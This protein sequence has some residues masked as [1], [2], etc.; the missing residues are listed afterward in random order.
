MLRSLSLHG[1][2]P[3]RGLSAAFGERLN[4]ITGDNGLGKS[5]LLDVC[6]WALTGTWP[7]GRTALPSSRGKTSRAE[8]TFELLGRSSAR[9]GPRTVGF[10]YHT[11]TWPRPSPRP[12]SAGLVIYAA[13]DGG[14]AVWDPA[15]NYWRDPASGL[16]TGEEQPRA[17]QFT[18]D[19]LADGLKDGERVLCNGLI[20]DWVNWY[21]ES[22]S[23]NGQS[24]SDHGPAS[25]FASL[26]E[27][28]AALAHPS[29]RMACA[30]PRR[31]YID[32]PRKYPVLALPYGDVPYPQWSAGMRR[33]VGLAYLLV[34]AWTE[35]AQAARLR[36]EEPLRRLTLIVDEVEAHL[37]P[38]WM[39]AILPALLR[40]E[41]RLRAEIDVQVL[42]A[43]HSP[44]I[45]AS[46]E[47]YFQAGRDKLFWFD[48]QRDTVRF[49]E[50]PWVIRGDVV[51]WLTSDIFGLRQ[52][53]SREAEAAIE[54]AEALMRGDV[55]ELPEGLKTREA[56]DGALRRL[57]SDLDPFW[58]RWYVETHGTHA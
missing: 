50:Y 47:P 24:A 55:E 27:V 20:Q 19:T 48:L 4:V 35:H 53:R 11:Q 45:L 23:G 57:L 22:R 25:P 21:Y 8:I 15:R 49:R 40:V 2:G 29:E 42:T 41:T 46:L 36:R 10:D 54:A 56:I 34:W 44:L 6:F 43:T 13:V 39:R 51:G 37:H 18:P 26:E 30:E 12:P 31:V 33:V 9:K 7:G 5:F 1:V 17:Y 14:F 38:R 58:P 52:A 28:V 32:Q 16:K 3:V